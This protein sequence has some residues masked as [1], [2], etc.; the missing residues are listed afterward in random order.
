MRTILKSTGVAQGGDLTKNIGPIPNMLAALNQIEQNLSSESFS[1]NSFYIYP[2]PSNGIFTLVSGSNEINEIEVFDVIGKV[3]LSKKQ[4]N[5]S[6]NQI[7]IDIASASQGIYF[8]KI[9]ANNQS[10]VKRI[11]KE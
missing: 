4:F 6:D 7:S 9:T 2:N 11:I 5:S 1:Q 10:T 8:L 3:I